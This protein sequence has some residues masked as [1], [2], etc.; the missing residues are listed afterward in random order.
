MECCGKKIDYDKRR[1]VYCSVCGEKFNK[2]FEG[3]SLWDYGKHKGDAIWEKYNNSG[4]GKLYFKRIDKKSINYVCYTPK[5]GTGVLDGDGG[6][7]TFFRQSININIEKHKVTYNHKLYNTEY[8]CTGFHLSDEF[9]FDKSMEN[10]KLRILNEIKPVGYSKTT[11]EDFDYIE[12]SIM[13]ITN[14]ITQLIKNINIL[15]GGK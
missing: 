11:K 8:D 9:I 4:I 1:I 7:L 2:E 6:K 10:F 13:G 12:S 3:K 14:N 15:N 5:D